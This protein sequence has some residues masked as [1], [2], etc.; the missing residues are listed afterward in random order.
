MTP[1]KPEHEVLKE[2]LRLAYQEKESLE[3]GDRWQGEV[4][5]RLR[6]LGVIQPTPGFLEMLESFI[7]RLVPVTCLLILVVTG[8]LVASDFTSEYEVIQL[9]MN[10]TEE[11]ILP[12]FFGL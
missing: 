10:G 11:L 3:V 2:I 6:K 9:L 8:V 7:W 12:P 4:M 1:R 5:H